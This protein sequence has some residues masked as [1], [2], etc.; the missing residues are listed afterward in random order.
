VNAAG[1]LALYALMI[2]IEALSPR[3]LRAEGQSRDRGTLAMFGLAIHGGVFAGIALGAT[4]GPWLGGWAIPAGA[5]ITAA[6]GVLRV[7]SIATLGRFFT[8]EVQV[9]GDQPVIESGP[10]ARIRHPSYTAL[11]VELCGIA[12]AVAN[13][14][15]AVLCVVPTAIVVGWRV[16]IEEAALRETL[17]ARWET[18]AVRTTR[19]VSGVF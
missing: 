5:M 4:R 14:L 15:A 3:P 13:P 6:G 2:A 8:R 18:Y 1:G 10:Y 9:S 17:G 12:L 19:F 16:R 7:W 11:I